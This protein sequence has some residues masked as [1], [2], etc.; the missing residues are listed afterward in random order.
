[1]SI[2]WNT[3]SAAERFRRNRRLI[4]E[5][6]NIQLEKYALKLKKKKLASRKIVFLWKNKKKIEK[7]RKFFNFEAK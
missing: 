6:R 2:I 7:N 5:N 4:L 1:M 3:G